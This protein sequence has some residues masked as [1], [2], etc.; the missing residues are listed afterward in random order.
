MRDNE[1]KTE[2]FEMI[3][4][5]SISSSSLNQTII[6]N[7]QENVLCNKQEMLDE[8][9]PCNHELAD[10]RLLLHAYDASR[11]R[12]RTLSIIAIDIEVVVIALYHFFSLHF[13]ELWVKFSTGQY[14]KYI[15]LHEIALSLGEEFCFNW[16]WQYAGR[17][18]QTAWKVW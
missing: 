9:Q 17:G 4:S 7:N 1:N 15:P 3:T 5:G 8:L 11:K 13:N 18:K 14:W 16:L 6:A 10:Y 12:F 2:P